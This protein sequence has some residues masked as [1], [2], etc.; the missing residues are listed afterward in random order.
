[1]RVLAKHMRMTMRRGQPKVCERERGEG[2]RERKK[3]R[4]E[5]RK[6]GRVEGRRERGMMLSYYLPQHKSLYM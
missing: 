6:E 1:M 3:G 4:E 2:G 5:R